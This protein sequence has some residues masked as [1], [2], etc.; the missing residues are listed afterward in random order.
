[1]C[2]LRRAL[3]AAVLLAAVLVLGG[4]AVGRSLDDGLPMVGLRLGDDTVVGAAA[5]AAGVIGGVIGGPAGA[6]L[7]STLVTA[8]GGAVWGSRQR[9]KGEH[10]GERRGWDEAVGT[11][12][13]APTGSALVDSHVPDPPGD[14]AG[15]GTRN[16][17][18]S[19]VGP[20]GG[21]A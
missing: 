4:C 7:A 3:P 14:H 19:R 8:I 11:P 12:A 21:A 6:V 10:A 1:M 16:M 13:G 20:A 17:A 9:V 15:G 2:H 5:D 18:A